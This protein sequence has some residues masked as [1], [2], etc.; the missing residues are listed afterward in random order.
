MVMLGSTQQ[1]AKGCIVISPQEKLMTKIRVSLALQGKLLYY[2]LQTFDCLNLYNIY[3]NFHTLH[4]FK[5][6]L[7]STWHLQHAK[8]QIHWHLKTN[9]LVH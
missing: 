5:L 8:I 2:Q 3:H 1:E 4:H 9:L 6:H 7:D